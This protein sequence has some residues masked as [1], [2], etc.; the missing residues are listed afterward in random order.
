MILNT[1]K[2]KSS[3]SDQ[4]RET[5]KRLEK[6]EKEYL[7]YLEIRESK[8]RHKSLV[9]R[10]EHSLRIEKLL[11]KIKKTAKGQDR[12]L[13]RH[14][15]PERPRMNPLPYME[16]MREKIRKKKLELRTPTP[17]K[18]VIAPVIYTKKLSFVINQALAPENPQMKIPEKQFIAIIKGRVY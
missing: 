4:L 14:S 16:K 7:E 8:I 18:K 5:S 12:K 13:I 6:I 9:E 10:A 15:M 11:R 3:Q 17:E 2:V 1:K